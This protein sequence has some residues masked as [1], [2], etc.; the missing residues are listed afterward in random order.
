[1]MVLKKFLYL[2]LVFG[3][4]SVFALE[5]TVYQNRY[6]TPDRQVSMSIPSFEDLKIEDKTSFATV[7]VQFSS[8]GFWM[9]DGSYEVDVFHVKYP[10]KAIKIKAY[11]GISKLLVNDTGATMKPQCQIIHIPKNELAYQ[12]KVNFTKDKAAGTGVATVLIQNS[13][14][15]YIVQVFGYEP[16]NQFNWDRYNAFL[17][18]IR[19]N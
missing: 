6:F 8:D 18:S 2:V 10:K 19:V 12:C 11:E 15:N 9:M 16:Q 3:C 7:N 14:K 13:N 1:M 17:R 4:T 5:G